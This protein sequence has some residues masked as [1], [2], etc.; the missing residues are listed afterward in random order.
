[1]DAKKRMN[2]NIW[3]SA[4]TQYIS[5]IATTDESSKQTWLRRIYLLFDI[6]LAIFTCRC[7]IPSL[8]TVPIFEICDQRENCLLKNTIRRRTRIPALICNVQRTTRTHTRRWFPLLTV[9]WPFST[10]AHPVF[11]IFSISSFLRFFFFNSLF[12]RMNCYLFRFQ[13]QCNFFLCSCRR[14]CRF[15]RVLCIC[16]S[17]QFSFS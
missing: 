14:A 3:I 17:K 16:S 15:L 4:T 13:T 5:I 2:M 1:M 10:S 6:I 11:T 12:R 9:V 7:A 8:F